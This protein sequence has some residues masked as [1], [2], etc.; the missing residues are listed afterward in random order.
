[1]L[2][3]L[4]EREATPWPPRGRASVSTGSTSSSFASAGGFTGLT[5]GI[6]GGG[7]GGGVGAG[8]LAAFA[9]GVTWEGFAG[10][11]EVGGLAAGVCV[12]G[13]RADDGRGAGSGTFMARPSLDLA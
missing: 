7:P 11:L 2:L 4:S 1:M 6:P 9:A 12:E 3:R 8:G 10:G 5:K 13:R